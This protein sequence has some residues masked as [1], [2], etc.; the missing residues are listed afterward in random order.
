MSVVDKYLSLIRRHQLLRMAGLDAALALIGVLRDSRKY[1]N[2]MGYVTQA[3]MNAEVEPRS[4]GQVV[5]VDARRMIDKYD[6]SVAVDDSAMR[7][8]NDVVQ[9]LASI[10]NTDI[11]VSAEGVRAVFHSG[12]F[13]HPLEVSDIGYYI[14]RTEYILDVP[15][16]TH[17]YVLLRYTLVDDWITQLRSGMKVSITSCSCRKPDGTTEIVNVNK[18][19]SVPPSRCPQV[20][21]ALNSLSRGPVYQALK[22]GVF[23]LGG[24]AFTIEYGKY[25][26]IDGGRL[27]DVTDAVKAVQQYRT[28][29]PP[30][31]ENDVK[32]TICTMVCLS[33]VVP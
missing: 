27:V 10:A 32:Q 19:Y 22:S 8:V 26:V 13:T 1:L 12:G 24:L 9:W 28:A 25:Y 5:G 23:E 15:V 31:C 7:L 17:D 20:V 33:G 4:L 14:Y 30:S 29:L 3:H 16:P 11:K 18:E 6:V 2:L 21:D